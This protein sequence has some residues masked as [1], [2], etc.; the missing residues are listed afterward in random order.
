MFLLEPVSYQPYVYIPKA[1][2]EEEIE[3]ILSYKKGVTKGTLDENLIVDQKI[4]DSN[5]CWVDIN[6]ETNWLYNKI[7][8]IVN[9]AN[10]YH[11]KLDL[12]AIENLQLS[13]Y[14]SDYEGFYGAHMDSN[15]GPNANGRKLSI[16]IQLSKPEDYDGGELKIYDHNIKNP[17]TMEKELGGMVLFRSLLIH[18]VTPVIKGIRNSL[19]SWVNGPLLK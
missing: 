7:T 16:S 11:F 18:E 14:S 5:V 15:W 12:K 1:F 3:K 17:F 4:R 10:Y 2:S 9:E 13:E 8:E 19:V 6:E